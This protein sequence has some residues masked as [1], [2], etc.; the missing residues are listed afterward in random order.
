[1]PKKAR[2][3]ASRYNRKNKQIGIYPTARVRQRLE[4]EAV[5]RRRKV[6]PTALLI[7]EEYFE[8]RDKPVEVPIATTNAPVAE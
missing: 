3:R 7:I 4:E 5:I 1:M 2:K 6:S 8:Q